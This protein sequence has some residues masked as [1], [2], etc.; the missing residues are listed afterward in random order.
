MK[1]YLIPMRACSP[2]KTLPRSDTIF[3][4]L[5]WARRVLDGTPDFATWL[6]AFVENPSLVVTDAF[7]MVVNAEAA[8]MHFLPKP[9]LLEP[10]TEYFQQ[11]SGGSKS[12]LVD[13][14]TKYK[15]FKKIEFI[16]RTLFNNILAGVLNAC[17]LFEAFL[18]GKAKLAG[19]FLIDDQVDNKAF[20]LSD[21]AQFIREQV[22]QRN[23]IDRV[24]QSTDTE[25]GQL[26]FSE[27]YGLIL[28]EGYRVHL[29][30]L[31]KTDDIAGWIP[32]L[33][34]ISDTGL[35]GDRSVGRAAIEILIEQI[36]L[37]DGIK[38]AMSPTHWVT[39][40]RYAPNLSNGELASV[41]SASAGYQMV[42]L[43]SK[44][45]SN[46]QRID[47]PWKEAVRVFTAGSIFPMLDASPKEYYGWLP[48][49]KDAPFEVY[50][51]G[52]AFPAFAKIK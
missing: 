41:K 39:L 6:K 22:S 14:I 52:L 35:G 26:F 1:T 5:C 23:R 3:G 2:V 34:W 18:Q 8:R 33:R 24:T 16:S 13:L 36:E 20:G 32:A 12:R 19:K 43:R 25:A 11:K 37:F 50:H 10:N 7:P 29:Y 28:G 46:W 21:E 15:K 49:V 31:M 42:T 45:E 17:G 4:A 40:S 38:D 51:N 9:Y 47:D 27:E 44:I 48:K 30:F